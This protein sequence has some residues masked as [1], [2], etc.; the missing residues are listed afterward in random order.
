MLLILPFPR[1][2]GDEIKAF[3]VM[4]FGQPLSD[5]E[6][7]QVKQMVKDHGKKKNQAGAFDE[8]DHMTLAG[9][10]LMQEV[11]L[12]KGRTELVWQVCFF[13]TPSTIQ[14]GLDY[15]RS[16]RN[17]TWIARVCVCVTC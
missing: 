5:K 8:N 15:C 12:Q 16:V 1:V 4:V 17:T 14:R 10:Y 3:Q 13:G 11:F 7:A 6:L 9:F 2:Q